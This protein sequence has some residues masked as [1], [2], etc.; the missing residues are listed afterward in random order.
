MPFW[1]KCNEFRGL[2][3][4][5]NGVSKFSSFMDKPC[6]KPRFHYRSYVTVRTRGLNS[7]LGNG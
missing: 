1:G 5:L 2:L 7:L 4:N 6:N 3:F